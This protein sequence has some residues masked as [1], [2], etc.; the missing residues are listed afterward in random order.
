MVTSVGNT[1]YPCRKVLGGARL[2]FRISDS[3]I[4]EI[5]FDWSFPILSSIT[6]FSQRN[7]HGK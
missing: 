1:F 2:V 5:L 6:L 4:Q 3:S 7:F